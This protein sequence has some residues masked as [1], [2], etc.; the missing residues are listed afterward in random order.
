MGA[1]CVTSVNYASR[2]RLYLHT[3]THAHSARS[4]HR[5]TK[6]I[7]LHDPLFTDTVVPRTLTTYDD[8]TIT[9]SFR[10]LRG[11]LLTA[12]ASKQASVPAFIEAGFK[13]FNRREPPLLFRKVKGNLLLSAC[14]YSVYSKELSSSTL[15]LLLSLLF[16]FFV[17]SF[18]LETTHC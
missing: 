18:L 9:L 14:E 16:F 15:S 6:L 13:R 2:F 7:N 10:E 1:S 5:A 3:H 17:F 8:Y 4:V 12:D 11:S